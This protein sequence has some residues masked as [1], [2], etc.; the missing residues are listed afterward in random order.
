MEQKQTSVEINLIDIFNIILN[1]K[2]IVIGIT[3]LFTLIG[4]F[5]SLKEKSIYELSSPINFGKYSNYTDFILINDIL[6][7]NNLAYSELNTGGYKL[8]PSF[9]FEIF[10]NEFN[11]FQEIISVL[12]KDEYIKTITKDLNEYDQKKVLF[13]HAQFFGLSLDSEEKNLFFNWHNIEEGKNILNEA[14]VLILN[15]VKSTIIN[16]LKKLTN[17]IEMRNKR[18]FDKLNIEL[19]IIE[20][21]E[22]NKTQKRILFLTEQSAIARELG[23][24]ES[25]LDAKSIILIDQPQ[26][27]SKTLYSYFLRGYMAI[28]KEI[29]VLKNRPKETQLLMADEY[30]MVSN[31]VMQIKNDLSPS[32]L[33]S[34][35]KSVEN[36]N[37]NE[38]I[39]Y[40][41]SISN[42][43][44]KNN[45]QKFIILF[46]IF[47]LATSLIF[48]IILNIFRK[49]ITN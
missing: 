15:N 49:Q 4:I 22:M 29:E 16:D 44:V 32:Q 11:D 1:G 39:T 25:I 30:V 36:F 18:Q 5:I 24:E 38:L 47:G 13:N 40:D 21:K 31:K 20:K 2:W 8:S 33:S 19:N 28:D 45:S 9:V 34:S 48:L 12:R 6:K 23:I 46:F 43:E 17:S 37:I 27:Q 42:V 10:K 41:L 3:L 14:L 26:E 7:E 35:I